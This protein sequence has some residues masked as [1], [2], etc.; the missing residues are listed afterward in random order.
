MNNEEGPIVLIE[1]N[2]EDRQLFVDIFSELE[3]SNKI[4]CFDSCSDAQNYLV[5]EKIKPFIVFSDI[6]LFHKEQ[7]VYNA[8]CLKMNC[9]CMFFTTLFNQCF[10]IDSY[11]IPT[12]SYFIKP[13]R[14]EKFKEVIENI[15]QYW[16][17]NKVEKHKKDKIEN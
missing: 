1:D 5:S 4:L 2:Q 7:V 15:I 6:R 3:L 8:I 14:Y 9:P 11:S 16:K 17:K 13:Y 12:Q 10:V